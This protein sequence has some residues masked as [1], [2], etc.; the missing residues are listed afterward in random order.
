MKNTFGCEIPSIKEI[1]SDS[2]VKETIATM[3]TD[4]LNYLDYEPSKSQNIVKHCLETALLCPSPEEYEEQAYRIIEAEKIAQ[5]IPAKLFERAN[6]MCQQISPYLLP[7]NLLDYGCGDGQ[8]SELIIKKGTCRCANLTDVYEHSHIKAMGLPFKLFTQ[9]G[10]APFSDAEFSNV[11]ALTVFHHSSNPVESIKD[12]SRVTKQSGR[13]IVV[14]SVYGVDG[15]QLP[16]DMQQKIAG[17][18]SLSAEQQRIVNVFFDHFYNRIISYNPN[19]ATK[20]NV[21]FNF[22]TPDNWHQLFAEQGLEQER[23]VHLGLDQPLAPE[24]HTL[25]VLRKQ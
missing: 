1:V 17:Y 19:P 8:V 13:V 2:N 20:V 16:R 15:K 25:H 23:V 14:E 24:Y 11:L 18:L 6:I 7:G 3:L 9:G 12:V 4:V 10:K 22:N 5:R 21:P